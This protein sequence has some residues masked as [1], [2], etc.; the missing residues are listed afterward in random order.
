MNEMLPVITRESVEMISTT[1]PEAYQLGKASRDACIAYGER[2]LE[3]LDSEGMS[4]DLDMAMAKY[5][6]RSRQTLKKINELRS[7]IT[8]LFD[9]FRNV[10]TTLEGEVN[11]ATKGSVPGR[12]QTARNQYAA[13]KRAEE[14]KRRA[15]AAERQ[16]KETVRNRFILALEEEFRADT[17]ACISAA[18]G[19]LESLFAA[20]TPAN[21][22]E[23]EERMRAFDCGLHRPATSR[24]QPPVKD[25][26]IDEIQ[27]MRLEV[28]GRLLGAAEEQCRFE[29]ESTRDALLERLPGK[30]RELEEI[31]RA[32]AGEAERRKRQM[33]EVERAEAARKEEKRRERAEEEKAAM[34]AARMN[35]EAESLF[36]EAKASVPAY[37]PKASVRKRINVLN[38]EGIPE[39]IMFWWSREGRTLPVEELTRKFKTVITYCEKVA[40]GPG[41]TMIGSEHIEYVEEVKA[42]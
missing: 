19:E 31:A 28:A 40:N 25:F 15:E 16:R 11:P 7:P 2:L 21:A 5:V 10:F 27:M 20:V 38:P 34:E 14:E 36:G 26:S 39:L 29:L 32:S 9:E 6:D 37:E 41:G 33:E 13:L 24:V 18:A 17:D 42:R 8:K 1:A 30:V 3:R 35:A 23:T 22:G 4:D 12:I